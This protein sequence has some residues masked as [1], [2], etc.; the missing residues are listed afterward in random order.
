MGNKNSG[1][2]SAPGGG[3]GSSSGISSIS[4]ISLPTPTTSS[5]NVRTLIERGSKTGVLK[6]GKAGVK[7]LPAQLLE[8]RQNLR[9]LDLSDNKLALIPSFIGQFAILKHLNLDSNRLTFLPDEIGHL[10]K[11]EFFSAKNNCICSIPETLEAIFSLKTLN[12]SSNRLT[13]FPVCITN[14]PNL[15]LFR[16]FTFSSEMFFTPFQR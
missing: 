14:L 7:E 2:S 10:K 11:L 8:L 13:Q 1:P 3:G 12:L 16:C 9:H 6:L 5:N 15:G 4:K